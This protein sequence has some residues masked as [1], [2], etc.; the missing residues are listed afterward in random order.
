MK[1][2]ALFVLALLLLACGNSK[3]KEIEHLT[4]EVM[5]VHDE[6][7]PLMD[8]L[9]KTRSQLQKK[10]D[11]DSSQMK[12]ETLLVIT[13]LKAGQDA[14]MGWMQN[15]DLQYEGETDVDTYSYFIEQKKTIWTVSDQIKGALKSGQEQLEKYRF[16][17]YEMPE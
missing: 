3:K 4:T 16:P 1:N 2:S 5:A 15:F 17:D 12:S 13:N 8:D 11:L 7:M 14:M 6:V 10:L 9:Y